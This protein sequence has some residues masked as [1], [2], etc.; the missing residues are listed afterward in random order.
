MITLWDTLHT[1]FASNTCAQIK[2]YKLCL[3]TAKNDRTISAYLLEIKKLVDFLATIG[4][5]MTFEDHV[6]AI[7]DGLSEDFN[8]FVAFI[9]S[10]TEPYTINEIEALLLA[11]ED[12]LDKHH[13][14]DPLTFTPATTVS[15]W[16]P[17]HARTNNLTV[18]HVHLIED[19]TP[20]LFGL[21]TLNLG[22]LGPSLISIVKYA[23]N[24][25]T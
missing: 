17:S 3:K 6:K 1:Y 24:L 16:N 19:L 12:R 25:A 8:P 15:S 5:P 14:V 20:L 21:K 11:Q 2:K 18:T 7:L 22:N 13:H 10:R 23:R 4:A 9:L